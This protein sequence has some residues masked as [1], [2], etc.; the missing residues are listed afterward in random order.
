VYCGDWSTQVD[1]VIPVAQGGTRER[2]NLVPSCARCNFEKL[3]FTP[4]EWR[5][6]RE[7]M[8]YPWPPPSR[9]EVFAARI[10]AIYDEYG[11]PG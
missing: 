2:T 5:A 8:G 3:D 9:T 11:L 4:A 10:K 6:W 1:H 7:S